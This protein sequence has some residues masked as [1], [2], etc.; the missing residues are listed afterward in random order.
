MRLGAV[1]GD[2]IEI[3]KSAQSR[4]GRK[5]KFDI[6]ITKITTRVWGE[7]V[8]PIRL[9]IGTQ[10]KFD[11]RLSK[12]PQKED[13]LDSAGCRWITKNPTV[14]P[15]TIPLSDLVPL[16]NPRLHSP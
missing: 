14:P 1:A 8:A 16:P 10:T 4:L 5:S 13:G 3:F 7:G 12:A 11:I 9:K 6:E 2:V 15:E